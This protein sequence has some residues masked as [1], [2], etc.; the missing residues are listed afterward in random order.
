VTKAIGL[1]RGRLTKI[2]GMLSRSYDGEVAAAGRMADA[3]VRGA[4]LTWPEV[5]TE[6]A[7]VPAFRAWRPP[8]TTAEA[9]VLCLRWPELL[10]PW[11]VEFLS[12]LSTRRRVSAKQFEVLTGILAKVEIA[13][14]SCGAAA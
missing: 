6:R 3:L 4:G 14:A 11:E 9:I 5:I 12:S 13:R 2:L 8:S 7:T 10:T 1:D